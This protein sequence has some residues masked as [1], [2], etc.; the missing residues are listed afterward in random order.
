MTRKVLTGTYA[1]GYDLHLPVNTIILAAS[2]YVGGNG[3][4]T[5][6]GANS[7]YTVVNHGSINGSATGFAG[8][9]VFLYDGGKVTNGGTAY[10]SA[11]IAGYRGVSIQQALGTLVNFAVIEATGRTG[12]LLEAGGTV[13]NGSLSD[14]TASIHTAGAYAA[15]IACNDYD[16][17]T[18]QH[19]GVAGTITNFGTVTAAYGV[20]LEAGGSVTNGAASD[21]S[22]LI[23]GSGTGAFLFSY[24]DDGKVA[25]LTNFGT[26]V[27]DGTAAF[28]AGVYMGPL[29]AGS[30][31]TNGSA[32]DA[33]ALIAGN[34]GVYVS[35]PSATVVDFGTIQGIGGVAV[36]FSGVGG[37]LLLEAGSTLLGGVATATPGK[38]DVVGG[39]AMITGD[40]ANV[41]T[42]V[43]AGSLTVR[44]AISL[45]APGS[46]VSRAHV[47]LGGAAYVTGNLTI[48]NKG[49]LT[50]R[51]LI[52]GADDNIGVEDAGSELTVTG[53]VGARIG[54]GA[55]VDARSGTVVD[56][57]GPLVNAGTMKVTG[58]LMGLYG[59]ISGAGAFEIS[60]GSLAEAG[61]FIGNVHFT[62][63]TGLL[64][65]G[66]GWPKPFSVVKYY[67]T[68]KGLSKTGTSSLDLL[69]VPYA[70]ATVTYVDNGHKTGGVLTVSG[71]VAGQG[72]QAEIT[73]AGDYT[74]VT[75]TASDDGGG[76]TKVT[77]SAPERIAL[78]SPSSLH[79]FVAALSSFA[80]S[81][82]VGHT[83]AESPLVM[84]R[85]FSAPRAIA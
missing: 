12:V 40:L 24:P 50:E 70:D 26:I 30:R 13:I 41:G 74:G 80:P 31:L 37:T 10:T 4:S 6:V 38:I 72:E 73:L 5:G 77:A 2:G 76:K 59:S 33:A 83:G 43:G 21:T 7:A 39:V 75:F 46:L 48:E 57:N 28:N 42:I 19:T 68:I 35:S 47:A 79:S 22:A 44:G 15:A 62:G 55:V 58:G 69:D 49:V 36:Y 78:P 9:G 84:Q 66:S 8:A 23:C 61:P 85:W 25:K 67:G 3:I 56:I 17:A 64:Y 18:T 81:A 53:P 63:P 60:G 11:S 32:A 51:T 65:L 71:D 52:V 82:V 54:A 1:S 29:G 34:T 14:R 27:G 20:E 45:F 16:V